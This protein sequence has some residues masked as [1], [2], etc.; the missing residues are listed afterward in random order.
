M[1]AVDTV[2]VGAGHA[3]LAIS[4]H[5]TAGGRDHVVLDR[6]RTAERWRSERW[7]SLRLLTPNWM[8]R[9]P[10]YDYGG[11]DPEGYMT[12]GELAELL[13]RYSLAL[14]L[15]VLENT[16]VQ[17]VVRA[18][19]GFVVT[20]PDDT[21]WAANV[22]VATGACDVPLVPRAG[23]GLDPAITQLTSSTYRNPGR[24]PDGGVLVVGASASGL[25]IADELRRAGREVVLA[26][27][28]HT[29]LPR[30]YRGM[31]VMWWLE[32]LGSLDRSVDDVGDVDRARREPSLQLVGRSDRARLD[33]GTVSA[34]GVRVTGRLTGVD[35]AVASFDRDLAD[36]VRTADERLR[37]LLQRIDEYVTA[38]GLEREVGEPDAPPAV[39]LPEAVDRLDLAA[40]GV[41]TVIW[42]T[43]YRRDHRWLPAEALDAHGELRHRYGMTPVPGLF[44]VGQRFQT[45]RNSTFIGGS[46]HDAALVAAHLDVV[47]PGRS[48]TE[49]ALRGRS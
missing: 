22:V 32:A 5:L 46:R 30:R 21:W 14:G 16:P 23:A 17:S 40:A 13:D 2:V 29:R 1:N 36:A 43:G 4:A 42:A 9:L 26:A 7:D 33:L 34:A 8:V 37:R 12:A 45:R 24:L 48:R 19:D 41:R 3:G 35:G 6:G 28:S 31:D 47:R 44:T 27:G 15:P 10:G 18:D 20:T 25:Q 11:P 49:V 39:A 38:H